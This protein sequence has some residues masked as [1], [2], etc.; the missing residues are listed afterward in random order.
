MNPKIS[1]IIPFFNAAKTLQR[2]IESV[3][4]QEEDFELI[5]VN[6]GSL[7]DSAPLV[8]SYLDDS[9]I[10]LFGKENKGVSTARNVGA[11]EAKGDWLL[12]LDADD[13]LR[14][15]FFDVLREEIK[16]AGGVDFLAFGINRIK[17]TKEEI[18]FPVDGHYFSRIPG[19]FVIRK[20]VFDQVGGYD[21]RFRFAENTELFHR[22]EQIQAKGKNIPFVSLNY[23]DNPSGGSKNL[24]NMVDS[25]S[26]FLEKHDATLTPHVKFLYHQIIGVNHLRFGQF[27]NARTCFWKSISLKPLAIQTWIRFVVSWL[28]V[29]SKKIYPVV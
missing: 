20:V 1:V 8:H 7:D 11:K 21:E 15:G 26:L 12:F 4:T 25:L 27:A 9:S 16:L 5:L 22:L 10:R 29:V 14:K 3:L 23:Y 17:G 2:A 28:P 19:T 13:E 18:S 6:D 24:K